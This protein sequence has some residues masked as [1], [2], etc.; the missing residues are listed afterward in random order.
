MLRGRLRKLG[1]ERDFNI[2]AENTE[3]RVNGVRFAVL[4]AEDA[5]TVESYLKT[6]AEDISAILVEEDVQNPVLSKMKVNIS[7]R[8][9]L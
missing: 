9:S 4:S 2:L 3:D 1:I 8:Y 6:V 7:E 5:K